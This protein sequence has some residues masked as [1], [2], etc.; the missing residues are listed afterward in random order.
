MVVPGLVTRGLVGLGR[1]PFGGCRCRQPRT[2]RDGKLPVVH[3]HNIQTRKSW[4][5]A[6]DERV[7]GVSCA[8][9]QRNA[10]RAN[11][12]VKQTR[13]WRGDRDTD[14]PREKKKYQAGA[15]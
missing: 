11:S 10:V 13:N 7:M 1:N 14:G 15:A 9:R 5:S 8:G 12:R 4:I 6:L 2:A 3:D